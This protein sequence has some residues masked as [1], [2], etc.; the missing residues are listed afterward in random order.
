MLLILCIIGQGIFCAECPGYK[1]FYESRCLSDAGGYG[2]SSLNAQKEVP[3]PLSGS[4]KIV[5]L[6][7]YT[8]DDPMKGER[9]PVES[10]L[11][12]HPV[13]DSQFPPT[14][15]ELFES[16]SSK[17]PAD[18]EPNVVVQFRSLDGT[19]FHLGWD[20]FGLMYTNA[21]SVQMVLDQELNRNA[22]ITPPASSVSNLLN[23][24]LKKCVERQKHVVYDLRAGKPL[25]KA[26]FAQM[27]PRNACKKWEAL[28]ARYPGDGELA[29]EEIRILFPD[30]GYSCKPYSG[31][32]PGPGFQKTQESAYPFKTPEERLAC[33]VYEKAKAK[34]ADLAK[35]SMLDGGSVV[36]VCVNSEGCERRIY[37]PGRTVLDSESRGVLDFLR[38]CVLQGTNLSSVDELS[39]KHYAFVNHGLH[40]LLHTNLSY[41]I[42]GGY[43]AD[44]L[45]QWDPLTAKDVKGLKPL[46]WTVVEEGEPQSPGVKNSCSITFAGVTLKGTPFVGIDCPERI[47]GALL[48]GN[49]L[50]AYEYATLQ[51]LKPKGKS[52]YE[53]GPHRVSKKMQW[54]T[55]IRR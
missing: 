24:V 51:K 52:W 1:D 6:P 26:C 33:K 45:G 21:R 13:E 27:F 22:W 46:V 25:V 38:C 7:P 43:R 23:G 8:R 19:F 30:G 34:I 44:R 11:L 5:Q 48:P 17:P 35:A 3:L 39:V 49:Y 10:S 12:P 18:I 36:V 47:E 53:P 41:D 15:A 40:A 55:E 28:P 37:W 2:Q 9:R 14:Y 32:A 31:R 29:K 16:E 20:T 42:A 54:V 4:R 50:W